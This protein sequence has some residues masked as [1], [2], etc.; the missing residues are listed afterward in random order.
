[1]RGCS[2]DHSALQGRSGGHQGKGLK[3]EEK[4]ADI[5]S[6]VE[7]ELL[8]KIEQG[9]CLWIMSQ[10]I[11]W[12]ERNAPVTTLATVIHLKSRKTYSYLRSALRP[13][14]SFVQ[15]MWPLRMI[16]WA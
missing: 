7:D 5:E 9:D 8:Y 12:L 2:K 16:E 3:H 10:H 13:L 11:D 6:W 15:P 1:M 14:S 4:N